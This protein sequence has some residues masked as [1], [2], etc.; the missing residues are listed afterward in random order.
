VHA[1]IEEMP[2]WV[3]AKWLASLNTTV[4]RNQDQKLRDELNQ[5]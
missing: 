1:L 2:E 5:K 4:Q 3:Y